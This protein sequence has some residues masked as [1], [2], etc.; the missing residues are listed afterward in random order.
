MLGV[1][2]F[3]GFLDI[4]HPDGI[5]LA[6][7]VW[8]IVLGVIGSLLAA[9]I[10]IAVKFMSQVMG[11]FKDRVIERIMVAGLIIAVVCYFIPDL[12]FSGESQIHEIVDNPGQ[13]GVAVLLLFAFLKPLLLALSLK[14]GYL[15]GP[16]FPSLFTAVM[17]AMAISLVVPGMP[18]SI[19]VACLE[20]AVVTLLLKAPITSILLV[21]VV[22]G[23]G[24]NANMVGL[25]TVASVTSMI[26]GLIFQTLIAKRQSD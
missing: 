23:A 5:S 25:I 17:V 18:P 19:L 14:S 26:M 16:V 4:G 7:V 2:A 11:V 15:G 24:A 20:V 10:G 21:T 6:W 22:S 1:P 8:A 12:M 9:Y 3:A 13:Y